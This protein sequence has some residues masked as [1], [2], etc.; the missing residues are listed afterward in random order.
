MQKIDIQTINE[1]AIAAGDRIL[2]IYNSNSFEVELKSDNS[3]LTK[4]DRY[5]HEYI[6]QE[7]SILDPTIPILSEENSE[8]ITYLE[9]K[10]WKQFWLVD[11]LDGTK[12]FIKRNGQFTVN[13]ALVENGK[14]ILG[15]IYAPVL[16][17]L[18]Y[19]EKDKGA[20]KQESGNKPEQLVQQKNTTDSLRTLV[21]NSH[22]N[23]ETQDYIAK[24]T[25]EGKEIAYVK[26][27][28]S[29]KFCLLAAG[30]ADIYP[31]L[32]PT[33]EWDTAAAQAI[34]QETGKNIYEYD[35]KSPLLYNKESLLNPYF[36]AR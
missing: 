31:R 6:F 17:A 8:T 2:D 5:S 23:Q 3:P 30:L 4:A 33:M 25:P 27:G 32:S 21:S 10:H 34:I 15:V 11:P 26:M 35:K 16:T 29:L 28:S 9:R 1:I 7:L 13:I 24:L 12:D 14:P 18:Y 36:I 22:L 20:Y 19:A